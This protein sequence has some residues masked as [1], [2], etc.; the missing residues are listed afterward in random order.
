MRKPECDLI[1]KQYTMMVSVF[2]KGFRIVIILAF[3]LFTATCGKKEVPKPVYLDTAFSF[4]ERAADL[5]SRLTIEEKQSLLGNTMAAVPRLGINTYYVWGEAL[6]GVVPM[7]NPYAGKATS[8]PSSAALSASW[9]PELMEREAVAI[10]DE[11]RAFNNP[12]IANLTYWSPVIEPIRDPRWGRTAETY[13]EDP[14]LIS[15]IGSGFIRGLMGNDPVY[16]KTVPCGKHYFANNSEFNRHIGSSNMDDRDMR[17][18]Y[19]VPYK[20]LIEKDKLP[21][22]MTCYNAVNGVPMSAN[23]YLVDTIPRKTYGLNGYITGDCG[24]IQDIQTGHLY[25]KTAAEAAAYGLRS[26]VDTDCGSVYQTATID[27]LSQGLITEAEIDQALVNLFTVRMRV[28]EFDP[29]SSV[30]W[31]DIDSSVVNCAEHVAL[32]AEV[33]KRTP[34]LLKNSQLKNS[35]KNVLPLDHTVLKKIALIGPQTDKVELGPYSGTPLEENMITPLEGIKAF[36]AEKQSGAQV[37]YLEGANTVSNANLFNIYWFEVVKNDGS[38]TR[39]DTDRIME[40]SKGI[41]V[42]AGMLP[43]ESIKSIVDGSWAAFRNVNLSGIGSINLRLAIP[44]DGGTIEFRL[45]SPSGRLIATIAGK[46]NTGMYSAFMPGIMNTP[47]DNPG[48]SGT[49]NIYMVFR[50]NKKSAIDRETI[51]LAKSSDVVVLFVGTDDK[52]SNE[53]ADRLTLE[54][55][56]NQYELIDAVAAVNPNTVVVMQTHGMVETDRFK[57][58]PNIAGIIWT[59]FNG[60]AQGTAIASILFGETNPGGKLSS[61]WFISMNDLPPITDYE[62]RGGKGKN[63]RTHWYFK[64]DVS[65]EFGYGLSYTTFEYGNF[66][67]DRNTVTPNDRIKVSVD[68]RNNGTVDGDEVVQV[69]LSTPD[70]PASLDR[71]SMRLEG[72]RRVSIPAGQTK[73]VDIDIDCADLWF[74]DSANDRMTFDQGRYVFGIGSSSKDIRGS[75]ETLMNGSFKP[76]LKT[77]V[78]ECGKVVLKPGDK[79]RTGVTAAMTDDSFYNIEDATVV[80]RSNNPAV[81]TVNESGEVT[82]VSAGVAAITAEVSIDGTVKSDSYPLKVMADLT[83]GGISLDGEDIGSFNPGVRSYSRLME[84]TRSKIP[85]VSAVPSVSGTNVKIVQAKTIPGTAIITLS[86]DMTGQT[87]IYTVNFGIPSQ[88]DA[89]EP[90]GLKDQWSWVRE[91]KEL[92]SLSDVAGNLVLT[93]A[94]GDVKGKANNAANI[95]LQSANSDWVT[96]TRMEFSQRPAMVDQQGGLIAYQ[97]DDNYVKLVYTNSRKGFMGSAEYIELLVES[98]G[99][100]Y[101][102]A[103]VRAQ[104]LVTDDL[105]LLL[106][107]EKKGS[108]YTAWYSVGGGDFKLLGTTDV[109]LKDVRAGLITFNGADQQVSDM[110]AQMMGLGGSGEEKP[111][112]V[113]FDYFNI[114][115][116]G[117]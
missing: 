38:V 105:V 82:A 69:Y 57:D 36:L 103:N 65:Y 13:G 80:F 61:T 81:A 5:V 56:G 52:T 89:F 60:Q 10:S 115:D 15:R 110:V 78:A 2:T 40:T 76:I 41:T 32:A 104:G 35:D 30:P 63:G 11:A 53:E 18:F 90:A 79:V 117:K 16:L 86:D 71:P 99:G 23:R 28:G 24:A 109:V 87:G 114:E 33:A 12:V 94:E 3:A 116:T 93:G 48:V 62:L 22:I 7:F 77:V 29:P 27:A 25:A 74:W 58:N 46:G 50:A 108:R 51:D 91:N 68:V 88:S 17:E 55:P 6:H 31:S 84:D 66:R 42:G 1:K 107:L 21:S 49:G 98:E 73:T 4:E 54:L 44:G 64:K 101:S 95:L 67:I 43:E 19:L 34:V 102:A 111:F 20:Y 97:D 26:G 59:S 8:F 106:R 96:E 113:R 39:Y 112:K 37:Q 70:S 85:D 75:L 72:F 100:E 47:V 83:L 92:W 14:F 45:G 9:D